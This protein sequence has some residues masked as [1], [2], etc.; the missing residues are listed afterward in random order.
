VAVIF[1]GVSG[2]NYC[3]TPRNVPLLYDT[4]NRPLL[5]LRGGTPTY[6][7]DARRENNTTAPSMQKVSKSVSHTLLTQVLGDCGGGE[8]GEGGG[9]AAHGEEAGS[10]DAWM[11]IAENFENKE[12]ES[13]I[14]SRDFGEGGVRERM[15]RSLSG[16]L[17]GLQETFL[18]KIV[19][20][21][22]RERSVSVGGNTRSHIMNARGRERS[23]SVGAEWEREVS[24]VGGG[25]GAGEE[26][27]GSRAS[28]SV[29]CL[30]NITPAA[31]TPATLAAAQTAIARTKERSASGGASGEEGGERESTKTEGCEN[32]EGVGEGV[33]ALE[34]GVGGVTLWGE[35]AAGWDAFKISMCGWKDTLLA[36]FV[37]RESAGG[38][39]GG[40]SDSDDFS[41]ER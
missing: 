13:G 41:V 11:G 6:A 39:G 4:N 2:S 3:M 38:E 8:G 14:G 25:G 23:V 20:T 33:Y 40:G 10:R 29:S 27:W 26:G 34:G 24:V 22:G 30:E 36:K 19:N 15:H 7:S 21:R 17:A 16:G 18:T 28:G 1:L 35:G 12:N 31:A 37:K 9:R 32:K 5:V